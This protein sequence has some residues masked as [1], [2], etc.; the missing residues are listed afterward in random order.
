[1][2]KYVLNGNVIKWSILKKKKTFMFHKKWVKQ[3]IWH[4]VK[5]YHQGKKQDSETP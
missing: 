4:V 5:L 2:K 1:M 3:I